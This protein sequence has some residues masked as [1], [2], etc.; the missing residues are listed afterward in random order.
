MRYGAA[1]RVDFLLTAPGPPPAYVEVK[2]VHLRRD[3]DWAE[4][5]D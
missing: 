5:P 1:S 3:G 2:N 4:F